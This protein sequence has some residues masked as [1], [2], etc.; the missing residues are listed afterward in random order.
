MKRILIIFLCVLFGINSLKSQR[1]REFSPDITVF[2]EEAKRF[3]LTDR[4][5]DRRTQARVV[6]LVDEFSP[7]FHMLTDADQKAFLEMSNAA[8]RANMRPFPTFENLLRATINFFENDQTS[9]SFNNYIRALTCIAK[10]RRLRDFDLLLESTNRM[11]ETGFLHE[12]LSV[13]WKIDGTGSF[14]YIDE[15]Q[16]PRFVFLETNLIGYAHND[17]TRIH[18]TRGAF[19]P[20]THTWLGEGGVVDFTR[21]GFD[22]SEMF[23]QLDVYE[24]NLRRA[25]FEADSVVFFNRIYFEQP[26]LGRLEERILANVRQGEASYPKFV[27]FAQSLVIR[28]IF[29]GVDFEGQY[30]QAGSRVRSGGGDD[31][32]TL[33]FRQ[34]DRTILTVSARNFLF[35]RNRIST[36]MAEV[37]IPI[38]DEEIRHLVAEVRYDDTRR[39]L[40]VLHPEMNAFRTPIYNSYHQLDMYVEAIYWSL[41]SSFMDFR[42]LRIPN[43]LGVGIFES[44]N[45]FSEHDME[46]FLQQSRNNPFHL[47]RR[48]SDELG[49]RTL[50]LR[51]I[52]AFFRQDIA[53]TRI[54]LFRMASMGF[55]YY[56]IEREEAELRPKLFHFLL[57]AAE[58]SDFDVLRIVSRQVD[59]PNARLNLETR[60]LQIFGVERV[61]LSLAQ[62][63]Y[64]I[65]DGQT[66]T[67][68]RN[69]DF[70]FD[71]TVRSGRFN[72]IAERCFFDYENFTISMDTIESM[73]F[74]VR[75][76]QPDA[77][78]NFQTRAVNAS[79]QELSGMI[80]IDSATNRSGQELFPHFPVFESFQNSYVRFEDSTIQNGVYLAEKFYFTVYPF[81]LENLHNFETENIR[82]PGHLTSA[83]IFPT[84]YEN[85]VV[86]PDFSLGFTTL[87]PEGFWEIY[88]GRGKFFDTLRLS[89]EGLIGS[90][91]MGF[92]TSTSLSDRFIFMPDSTNA[93]I[94]R[95]GVEAQ[96]IGPEFPLA[97]G[98]TADLH[99]QPYQDLFSVTNR[100]DGF[101]V[102][103]DELRFFGELM[104]SSGGMIGDG[105]AVFENNSEMSS[106]KFTIRNRELFSENVEFALKGRDGRSIAIQSENYIA[107]VNFDAQRAYFESNDPTVFL[108]FPYIQFLCFINELEWDMASNMAYL[109]NTRRSSFSNEQLDAMTLRELV[110]IGDDLPGSKFISL[111]PRQ[112]SLTFISP[113]AQY[114]LQT[115]ELTIQQVRIVYTADIAVQP[116]E[117]NIVIGRD[118]DIQPFENANLLVDV[119]NQFFDVFDATVTIHGGRR[120]TASGT[121][122]YVDA[123]GD[124]FP[125][126]FERLAPNR[127]GITTGTS[128]IYE[129]DDFSLSPAF[130]F[131]GQVTMRANDPLLHF[132]GNSIINHIC[133]E[134]DERSWFSINTPI[135]PENV[136]IPISETVTRGGREARRT[137]GT[138]F[139]MSNRGD[140]FPAFFSPVRSADRPVLTRTGTLFF[141]N[142]QR[143][144]IIEPTQE[145]NE[146]GLLVFNTTDCTFTLHGAP[147]FNLDLGRVGFCSFGM[148]QHNFRSGSTV[149]DAV[150]GLDFF[151]E[152]RALNILVRNLES[153]DVGAEQSTDKFV[154]FIRSQLPRQEAER[155]EREIGMFGSIRRLP[156]DLERTI[157]FSDVNLQW[158]EGSRSFVSVGKLGVAA[159]GSTQINRSVN[160]ILQVIRSPRGDVLNLYLEIAPRIWFFF[161]Y[162]DG[163]MQ[164]ISSDDDFNDLITSQRASNRRL[165]GEGRGRY[166]FGISTLR[167]RN[168]FLSN[169]NRIRESQAEFDEEEDTVP[170]GRRL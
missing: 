4:N 73:T 158:D 54:M 18:S 82:F 99:W 37:V 93:I 94:Q 12:S 136:R 32:A 148:L 124:A 28:D 38:G 40:I 74:S 35:G 59:A 65:P 88:G 51:A 70:S 123:A 75:Y 11:F 141:D 119:Y 27:S 166:E 145:E 61:V 20:L 132:S 163:L 13:R 105:T 150:I 89:N 102:F 97:Q 149:F 26:L 106:E 142:E 60:G 120:F 25:R 90:G 69:R 10:R 151:F 164:A 68:K 2:N 91:K 66:I 71:G 162:S 111:H 19:Y 22:I 24:I 113:L 126:F 41:D 118:S 86:M 8:L 78:G 45:F 1:F 49:T 7:F 101:S 14:E 77:F 42:M 85:L 30:T 43:N 117:G 5:A 131:A 9:V 44:K 153:L 3:F 39:E 137:E 16:S 169:I 125:M 143:S 157:L 31:F 55:L 15:N 127:Y 167:H 170:R 79:I 168:L 128:T 107:H 139:Y 116:S 47:L 110:A 146:T 21:A 130:G 76:G 56:N 165:R 160:G 84:I 121:F 6:A 129:E 104:L 115:N 63:V 87:P 67:M 140:L 109:K 147:D 152:Q 155:L 29:E 96:T 48:M 159:V 98:G 103:D 154:N 36:R 62:N 58:R 92:M 135:D 64:V 112:D 95:F 72:F 114:N 53:Q 57:S 17:S 81:R 34:G 134:E 52:A 122:N 83:G 100:I 23:A 108:E 50:Q 144:Y 156:S 33:R 133:E 80:F 161:S 46:V 138:G